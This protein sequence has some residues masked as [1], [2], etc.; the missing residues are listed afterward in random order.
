MYLVT[1]VANIAVPA[2]PTET[3][4]VAACGIVMRPEGN[5]LRC[6]LFILASF[7]ISKT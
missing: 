6:V 7:F 1:L 3:A 4:Q 5:G 2:K